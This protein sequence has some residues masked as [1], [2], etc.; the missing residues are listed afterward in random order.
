M[1]FSL[2]KKKILFLYLFY[3]KFASFVSHQFSGL[4]RDRVLSD[5]QNIKICSDKESY[6]FLKVTIKN[7]NYFFIASQSEKNFPPE[8]GKHLIL[9]LNVKWYKLSKNEKKRET[10]TRKSFKLR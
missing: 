1:S 8:W 9:Q 5:M 3:K 10:F 2:I 6:K 7:K 4:L